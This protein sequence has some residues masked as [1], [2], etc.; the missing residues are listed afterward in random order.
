MKIDQRKWTETTGWKQ[1][2]P[3]SFPSPPQ[4]VFVFGSTALLKKTKYFDEVKSFYPQSHILMCSTAG[5]IFDTEVSD[6]S[7][8]VAAVL[9]EKSELRFEE[10]NV[11]EGLDDAS[12]VAG[13]KLADSLEKKGL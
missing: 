5:E 1:L 4:V 6:D 12:Y 7:A 9:F 13:K 10:V 3:V 11:A 2:S 8:V